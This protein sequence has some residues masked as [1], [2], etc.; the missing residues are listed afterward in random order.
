[1]NITLRKGNADPLF[2]KRHRNHLPEVAGH[3]G[4]VGLEH[5]DPETNLESERA[6]RKISKKNLRLRFFFYEA[7]ALNDLSKQLGHA[8]GIRT[9]RH[10]DSNRKAHLAVR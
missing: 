3:L 8:A 7:M 4:G 5:I 1:M 2:R 10:S 6:L 9:I